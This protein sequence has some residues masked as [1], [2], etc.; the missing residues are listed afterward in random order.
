MSD[1]HRAVTHNPTVALA[2]AMRR[3]THVRILLR[4]FSETLPSEW[5]EGWVA[6][7]EGDQAQPTR[8]VISL[9]PPGPEVAERIVRIDRVALVEEIVAAMQSPRDHLTITPC[10]LSL[11]AMNFAV[12]PSPQSVTPCAAILD[13]ARRGPFA[14][15]IARFPR[16]E[17]R[18]PANRLAEAARYL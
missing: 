9:E 12:P 7:F 11:D 8:V 15:V 2:R 1:R 10:A 13:L 17:L 5:I 14:V 3:L 6:R 4:S 18:A 16:S